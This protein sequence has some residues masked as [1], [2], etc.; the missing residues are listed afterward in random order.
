MAYLS[1]EDK[2]KLAPRIKELF[3]KYDLKGSISIRNHSTLVVKVSSGPIDFGINEDQGYIQ[4]NPYYV[5][6][7]YE[8]AAREF[9]VELVDA[10]RGPDY[11]DDSDPM[12]DYFYCSHYISIDVGLWDK[13]YQLIEKVAA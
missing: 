10:M 1:Q 13:P 12:T 9:L 3:K 6:E 7:H 4:V 2:K 8:G 5:D 11:F